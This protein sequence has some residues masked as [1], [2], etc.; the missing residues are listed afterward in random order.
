MLITNGDDKKNTNIN[1]PSD[2][3]K[4]IGETELQPD[5]PGFIR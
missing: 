1:P 3:A 5:M 2:I 4:R